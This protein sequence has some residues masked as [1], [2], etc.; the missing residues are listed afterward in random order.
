MKF[1]IIF[2]FFVTNLF[3]GNY[4]FSSPGEKTCYFDNGDPFTFTTA[5]NPVNYLIN[6]C[7]K[8]FSVYK[9]Y[10]YTNDIPNCGIW[11]SIKKQSQSCSNLITHYQLLKTDN[12]ANN[13]EECSAIG[14][15]FGQASQKYKDCVNNCVLIYDALRDEQME[16]AI[17]LDDDFKCKDTYM[18]LDTQTN[19]FNVYNCD[20]NSGEE[21]LIPNATLDDDGGILCPSGQFTS[22]LPHLV[23]GGG[24]SWNEYSCHDMQQTQEING[25]L[26]HTQFNDKGELLNQY[27][28]KDGFH[29]VIN[30]NDG[31]LEGKIFDSDGN[32]LA[33]YNVSSDIEGN[34]E[35][36]ENGA[37][38]PIED[39]YSKVPTTG[40]STGGSGGSS[41]SGDTGANN[42][43][44]IDDLDNDF[45]TENSGT[46][47][48][49]QSDDLRS[50]QSSIDRNT[51]AL[52]NLN[53]LG[54]N[55]SNSI[56]DLNDTLNAEANGS[57]FDTSSYESFLQNIG[58]SFTGIKNTFDS[59]KDLFENGF[60]F[61]TDKFD[62][63]VDCTMST[64]AFGQLIQIDFCQ[65]FL[66]FR[67]FVTFLITFLLIFQSIK[68]FFWGL[69]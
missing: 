26:L 29:Y 59:T 15:E 38:K 20:P 2:I 3:S 14:K 32:L 1:L 8:T 58:N 10:H 4:Y 18:K 13:N 34:L 24:T 39:F 60:S 11:D 55:L 64:V 61:D 57:S 56:N 50:L 68:I 5:Q 44:T 41:G 28:E 63:Y 35:Y 30:N 27:Y 53:G 47:G 69:K 66:P 21:K 52:N 7:N 6:S 9:G 54:N 43:T 33:E 51:N 16:Q 40:G 37:I 62:N 67:N 19:T 42:S 17:F 31:V 46:G 48:N 22:N 36:E 12:C 23:I 45:V 65:A 25:S 49:S